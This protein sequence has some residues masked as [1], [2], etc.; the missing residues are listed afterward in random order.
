GYVGKHGSD[1]ALSPDPWFRGIDLRY[2]PDGGVFVLDWSDTGECH[3]NTGVHRTSGRI[4]KI[5]YGTPKQP[6]VRDLT[7]LSSEELVELHRHP[8]EWFVRQARL[9]LAERTSSGAPMK[10]V[11]EAL[12]V[13]FE[14]ERDY[15]VRLRA[16]FSLQATAGA[17]AP[18]LRE[19]LRNGNE[20]I[21]AWALRFLTDAWPLDDVTGT[22]STLDDDRT[23][24]KDA[25]AFREEFNR[26][27]REDSSG[28]VRL[29][30]ASILQR[31]PIGERALL[32]GALVSRA[33]DA[34]DHN[35]PLL[36]WYGLLPVADADPGALV[37]VA[38]GC[39]W[40]Q[41]RTFIAR[42]LAEELEK[43]PGPL[44]ELLTV[45][46]TSTSLPWQRDIL[47]GVSD[48]LSG[49]RKAPKPEAWA[50]LAEKLAART[51][52]ALQECIRELS[53]VFG[54]GRALDEIRGIALNPKAPFNARESALQALIDSHPPDLR[55]VCE[56][57]LSE[58]HLNVLAV[59]GL[60]Q[61]DDPKIGEALVNSY[62]KFRESQRPQVLSTLVTRKP[63]A[64]ALLSAV[65][66]GKIPRAEVS[67]YHIR[68][69]HSFNDPE[70]TARATLA[71]GE[72]RDSPAAKLASIGKLKRRMTADV[73]GYADKSA[74]RIT[75]AT[76][77][78]AC[79]KMYGEG[80]SIGPD[81][82][83]SG[84]DNLDYLLE[85][86]IDPSA[87]VNAD[88]R[89]TVVKMK[90]G[91]V[92]NGIVTAQTDRTLTIRSLTET[93]TVERREIESME[94][95]TLSQ[96]PEG[97]LEALSEEQVRDLLAYLLHPSQVPLPLKAS[98]SVQ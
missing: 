61:F 71:W 63:F 85:N 21:R 62:R 66:D 39:E 64:H 87:V 49:W 3:E 89:M 41:T 96:M 75:F 45:A 56:K 55:E 42:R 69:I 11:H 24:Q 94:T 73:L 67:A 91:R 50:T 57:L 23:V 10:A 40:P 28:L 7:K 2:G 86:I 83:G 74:G 9:I 34:T 76:L 8:N 70:L 46:S 51:D 60:A 20:H 90:D 18:F 92:L 48:A 14:K 32:A 4:Y 12:Q 16:L 26:L 36:V 35:L 93:L 72:L 88:F 79:H 95:S 98:T 58:S 17:S 27:A 19:Q 6:E 1:I 44:N 37:T 30:L 43:A 15:A 77:C 54:D 82:T 47:Q 59:R 81:L 78:A 13:L 68:Q 25:A 97:L 29:T 33:E 53:A 65:A 80:G 22:P 31:M 52:A 5:T 38:R 84:R